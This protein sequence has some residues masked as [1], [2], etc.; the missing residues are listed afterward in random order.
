MEDL[1]TTP[2]A[3]PVAAPVITEETTT[4]ATK[5]T[6]ETPVAKD[7]APLTPEV[8]GTPVPVKGNWGEQKGKLK[9]QFSALTDEDL[10]YE[11]GKKEEMFAKVQ[12]KL[13]KTKEEFA[14]IVAA[15]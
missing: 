13:G 5:E 4:P 8:K 1:K 11:D 7:P 2:V 15:L 14:A 10:R 6:P 9:A 12:V 3:G